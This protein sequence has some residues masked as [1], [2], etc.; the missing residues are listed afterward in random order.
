MGF[1]YEFPE[2]P[3][4]E[5]RRFYAAAS[6]VLIA[7]LLILATV[8]I[9]PL[10]S[11]PKSRSLSS[12]DWSGYAVASDFTNPQPLVTRVSANWTVPSVNVS[13]QDTFCA[14]WI[15]IGG[16]FDTTL[17]QTGTEQDSISGEA[18]YSAWYEVLPNDLV[19]INSLNVSLGDK[20]SA[21]ISLIDPTTNTWTIEISDIS[22]LQS[23][24]KSLTYSSSMLS[25]EWIVERPT[26][27][28]RISTLAD[29][30]QVTFTGCTATIGNKV[31]VISSF[32]N[33]QITMYNRQNT[34]L[35][36][37]STLTSI[38]ASFT[39]TYLG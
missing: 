14:V 7:S 11:G 33:F 3:H 23:F 8:F 29:F 37:T 36:S 18:V 32:P 6:I 38:G 21:K 35:A 12:S 30:G 16:Q 25:A 20:I 22:N 10:L 2:Q 34:A 31:G 4:N 26:I 1:E 24:Q 5:R 27:N 9:Y 13:V 15:G 28:N 19:T 39:A 17:I